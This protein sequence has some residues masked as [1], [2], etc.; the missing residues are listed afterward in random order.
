MQNKPLVNFSLSQLLD[1]LIYFLGRNVDFIVIGRL[2]GTVALGYYTIAYN[3]V[4]AIQ[5]ALIPVVLNVAYATLGRVNDNQEALE[6]SFYKLLQVLGAVLIP[7][8]LC[9]YVLAEPIVYLLLGDKWG[10]SVILVK[11]LWPVG[12]IYS[13]RRVITIFLL[14]KGRADISVLSSIISLLGFTVMVYI[15]AV[16][17][18]TL[19][20]ALAVT[21]TY[22]ILIIPLDT[23]LGKR[24]IG[25][26]IKSL[27]KIL[28]PPLL[29]AIIFF[30]YLLWI[31]SHFGGFI[32]S[33]Y[34]PLVIF[35]PI[36]SIIYATLLFF[37][38]RALF[39]E[40]TSFIIP[41]KIRDKWY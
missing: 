32:Q 39:I 40:L 30:C 9:L 10:P 19:G 15:G 5:N 35:L 29:A 16:L 11:A 31:S 17:F 26:K 27:I 22:L 13:Y 23:Y 20:V 38:D 2:F 28:R 3:F 21:C 41:L 34:L 33:S 1:R 14:L 4:Y 6:K 36:S 18:N 8:Y 12:L 7:V 25:F 37:V 24:E